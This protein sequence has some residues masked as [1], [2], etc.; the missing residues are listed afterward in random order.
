LQINKNN[1]V[2]LTEETIREKNIS[3]Y[4]YTSLINYTGDI[5]NIFNNNVRFN[6][7]I[8]D[9]LYD[10]ISTKMHT[11]KE[12]DHLLEKIKEAADKST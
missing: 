12:L 9:L 8:T 7:K 5:D 3:E 6:F 4:D 10:Q 2:F 11:G 1:K